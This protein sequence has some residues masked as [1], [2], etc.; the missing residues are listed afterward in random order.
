MADASDNTMNVLK[1]NV[2]EFRVPNVDHYIHTTILL[3][4]QN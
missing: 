2:N 4:H 1:K 3:R